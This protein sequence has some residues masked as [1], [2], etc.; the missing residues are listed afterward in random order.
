M[1]FEIVVYFSLKTWKHFSAYIPLEV[2][3]GMGER[4]K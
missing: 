3:F 1:L 2:D 4:D